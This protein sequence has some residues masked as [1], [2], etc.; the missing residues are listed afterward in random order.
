MGVADVAV[1]G[2]VTVLVLLALGL[3][4]GFAVLFRRG[5]HSGAALHTLRSGAPVAVPDRDAA[6]AQ[7]ASIL[8]L[9]TDDAVHDASDELG[10]AIAQF[11]A[12]RTKGLEG[13]L[14]AARQRLAEAFELQQRLDDHVPD[15][16]MQRREWVA[17]IIHLCEGAQTELEGELGRF[18]E[19]REAERGAPDSI[20]TLRRLVA[21]LEA[22][23][24]EAE[25]V[26]AELQR[27]Y[28]PAALASVAD[29]LDRAS[30]ELHDARESIDTAALSVGA[31]G[32]TSGSAVTHALDA[33]RAGEDHARRAGHLLTAIEN[34][35]DQLTQASDALKT[36]IDSTRASLDE[37]RALRDSATDAASGAEIIDA[38]AQ[39]ETCL[40][41]LDEGD[42]VGALGQLRDANQRLDAALAGARN[43]EQRLAQAREAL[44]GALVAA[45]SQVSVTHDFIEGRRGGVGR[46]ARTRLAEAERLLVLAQVEADP[47]AALDIARSAGTYARDADALAR[48]DMGQ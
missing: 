44:R 13:A 45:R 10:F 7:R 27:D 42:P 19:L 46:E 14:S 24:V 36:L 9:R 25:T 15:S 23:E 8:L 31:E 1:I 47:V 12:E 3:A 16:L 38:V 26:L 41:S 22:R 30:G 40:A 32:E 21:E 35:R 11:G 34:L 43:R 37:A 39:V 33:L 5:R 2:L 29:S 28:S 20:A 6:E 18:D 4:T 48:Y 17:R